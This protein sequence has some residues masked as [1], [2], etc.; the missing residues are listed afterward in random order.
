MLHHSTD[1][2]AIRTTPLSVS[3]YTA[4]I[5]NLLEKAIQPCWIQGEVSNLRR[6]SSGHI[7]FTLKD[8]A[9]QLSCVLFRGDASRQPLLPTEG[10]QILVHGRISVYE[11]R[12]NYQLI[13][14][15]LLP[16]GTGALQR[17]FEQLKK[18]LAA[19]GLFSSERKQALPFFPTRIAVITSPSGAAVRDFVRILYRRGAI[20]TVTLL[21]VRVQGNLAAA[22]IVAALTQAEQHPFDLI[23]LTRGG[24][25]LEDLWPFNEESVVRAI[26]ASHIPLI[27]AV[28]HEIDFTLADFVADVR[29]ETPSAAAERI[30]SLQLEVRDQLLQLQQSL[31]QSLTHRLRAIEHRLTTVALRLRH[32][33]PLRRTEN[34]Y[35]RLD[36]LAN[37]LH[38]NLSRA[39]DL[40]AS[41]L[42]NLEHRLKQ[43]N[44]RNKVHLVQQQLQ[45]LRQRLHHCLHHRLQKKHNDCATL[46]ARLRNVDYKQTLKRGFSIIET[47]EQQP[48]TSAAHLSTGQMV[49]LILQDG[50]RSARIEPQ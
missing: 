16:D 38:S 26:A 29:A 3:G 28:G 18:K 9:S 41:R 32:Q 6:Q 2:D 15:Q 47:S 1:S 46:A 34:L 21:P 30:T 14:R 36:D 20:G 11:P 19:E 7:Y 49:R 13:V 42:L 8:E 22:E 43:A 10:M 44:P 27:S 12:G 33:S 37:Q 5:K 39:I 4:Q 40:K 31:E 17:Q 50:N 24:G 48:I 23:V 25:S 35:L 45:F